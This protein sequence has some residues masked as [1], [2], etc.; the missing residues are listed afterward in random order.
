LIF[1][2]FALWA[3]SASASRLKVYFGSQR[4][5]FS[6]ILVYSSIIHANLMPNELEQYNKPHW[7]F[8]INIGRRIDISVYRFD[9]RCKLNK[10][11]Y[12]RIKHSFAI[13]KLTVLRA[14]QFHSH[15]SPRYF[16]INRTDGI[17]R[18]FISK[19]DKR[20]FLHKYS[21]VQNSTIEWNFVT[22]WNFLL[23][24]L[25]WLIRSIFIFR[26]IRNRKP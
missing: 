3:L 23:A 12:V 21:E 5:T 8:I 15:S 1:P 19:I 26:L 14:S 7:K 11:I 22:I 17:Y 10:C 2:R 25:F 6:H 18:S 13:P 4:F 20:T 9:D 16:Q 24:I